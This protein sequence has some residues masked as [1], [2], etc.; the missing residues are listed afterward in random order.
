M[1]VVAVS[2]ARLMAARLLIDLHPRWSHVQ[3]VGALAE[4]LRHLGAISDQVVVA[5][6]LHDIGYAPDLA[7]T[8]FHP[9]DGA[10]HLRLLGAAAPVV[11]LVAHHTGADTEARIRGVEVEMS[12]MP[13]A[14][15]AD[16]DLL[17]LLDLSIAPDGQLVAPAD[18]L[19]EILARH[20]RESPIHISRSLDRDALLVAS[21][22]A[23]TRLGENWY[24]A[25]AQ[26]T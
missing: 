16:L 12:R 17:T 15:S 5:A 9:L 24:S 2:K 25:T 3:G 10:Q 8:G 11:A 7:T 6:W 18:R 21:S 20:P 14:N 23:I 19:A 1:V 22:R 13:L 4:R 26:T